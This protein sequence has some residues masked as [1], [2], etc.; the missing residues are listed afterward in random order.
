[1]VFGNMGDDSGTGVAFTRNPDT[2]SKE[3][4]G[5]YL[6]NAQGEDVVAGI[7]TPQKISQL[8]DEMPAAYAEFLRDRPAARAHYR[9][10]QD[11]EF[12]IER[13]K[14]YMLQTRIAKRTAAAAVKIAVRHG[15]RGPHHRA[16]GRRPHRAGPG[17]PAPARPVR[18]Q[19]PQGRPAHRQGPQ[20]LTRRGRRARRLQRR[21]RRRVGRAGREG[22]PRA[23]RDVARTTSTAWPSR[24]AS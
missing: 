20:R 24:R 5:E 18:P 8:E 13:G 7:R 14:L 22:R 10:V 6:I 2:A 1:M 21:R 23:R 11:L 17:G 12:T 4:Y 3:L 19:R 16:R 15:R 9:D